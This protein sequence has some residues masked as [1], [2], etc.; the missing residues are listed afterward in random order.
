MRCKTSPIILACVPALLVCCLWLV[1][2]PS[3][4]RAE[5][6]DLVDV[7]KQI[8]GQIVQIEVPVPDGK[9]LGTGFW[10]NDQGLLATCLHVVKD[11]QTVYVKSAI[12]SKFD[13]ARHANI[14][15]NWTL[16]SAKIVASDTQN[17]IAI[18]KTDMSPFGDR[19]GFNIGNEKLTAHYAVATLNSDLPEAGQRVLLAGYPL[20]QPYLIVQEGTIAALAY[21]LPDWPA[22]NKI[23]VSTLSNH[24]NSGAP[25]FDTQ[26]RVIGVLEGEDRAQGPDQ[27]R[28]AISVV[29]PAYFVSELAKTVHD[30]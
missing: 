10:L 13:L 7:S 15:A 29:I 3:S 18:L 22:A 25:L 8:R 4:A 30:Q 1:A 23:L 19:R 2:I 14:V 9:L 17:D 6:G 16:F 12:D 27:E 24:G 26:G 11:K 28:T 5:T 20:G 21:D